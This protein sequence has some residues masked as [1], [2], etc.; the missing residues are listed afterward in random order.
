[1]GRDALPGRSLPAPRSSGAPTSSRRRRPVSNARGS[2]PW[3]PSAGRAGSDRSRSSVWPCSE[4]EFVLPALQGRRP[5][6]TCPV[7]EHGTSRR[8]QRP[9]IEDEILVLPEEER[10]TAAGDPAFRL[11][12]RARPEVAEPAQV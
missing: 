1:P 12:L 5:D 2:H 9:R 10:R 4:R 11:A 8:L 3:P 7:E 6:S